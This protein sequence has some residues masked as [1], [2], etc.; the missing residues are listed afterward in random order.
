[1][2]AT[3]QKTT[4]LL[5]PTKRPARQLVAEARGPAGT[6]DLKA[7]D[8]KAGDVE[9][10]DLGARDLNVVER[11]KIDPRRFRHVLG[12]FATG[13]T[14]VTMLEGQEKYGITVN[15]FM[16]VSLEP[17]LIAVSIDRRANAHATMLESE[18]F[19]VSVLRAEQGEISNYFAGR[20]CQGIG[21]VYSDF[22]GFPVIDGALAHIV[23]RTYSVLEGG[24]HTIF[25]GEVEALRTSPG[26]P[27]LYYRGRYAHVHDMELSE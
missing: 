11:G 6:G 7:G 16:S 5:P 9:A 18:R 2:D 20:P 13:I 4:I 23:C 3:T 24:D 25:L 10:G 17:A 27:L 19:G 8:L 26:M 1:M 14:V 15:A 12:S 21:D 22:A